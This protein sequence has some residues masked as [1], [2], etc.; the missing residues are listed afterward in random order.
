MTNFQLK[1]NLRNRSV[2]L[3]IFFNDTNLRN[4]RGTFDIQ[5]INV[6]LSLFDEFLSEKKI[7]KSKVLEKILTLEE[8]LYLLC[9]F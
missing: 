3:T 9:T 1:K 4:E 6:N 2:N 5:V 8:H 7:R